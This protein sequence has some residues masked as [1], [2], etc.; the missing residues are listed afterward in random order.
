MNTQMVCPYVS[1]GSALT[2][3]PR[4]WALRRVTPAIFALCV[5]IH[6]EGPRPAARGDVGPSSALCAQDDSC[7]IPVLTFL[8]SS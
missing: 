4:L 3:G 2:P 1:A 5:L 6:P 7:P 8:L